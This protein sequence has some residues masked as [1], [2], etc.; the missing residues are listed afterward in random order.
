MTLID[1]ERFGGREA[2]IGI[3]R[4]KVTYIDGEIWGEK[5]TKTKRDLER[6]RE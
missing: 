3:W 2:H 6:V 1:C 5:E 4:E